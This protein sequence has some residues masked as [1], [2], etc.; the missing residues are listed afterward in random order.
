MNKNVKYE[1]VEMDEEDN[2]D[3]STSMQQ[4]QQG[5]EDEERDDVGEEN[6][7]T[8]HENSSLRE[9]ISYMVSEQIRLKL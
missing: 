2:A 6:D 3:G 8:I 9:K 4:Q 1:R 5:V 7:T